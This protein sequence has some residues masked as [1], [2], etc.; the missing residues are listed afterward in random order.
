[1]KII[2]IGAILLLGVN[3][4][5]G[6]TQPPKGPAFDKVVKSFVEGNIEQLAKDLPAMSA[7]YPTHPFT[8]FFK[9]FLAD[10][11]DNN[12]SEALRG[13]SEA[14]KGDP[15]LMEAYMY[16]GIIVNEKGMYE[17]AIEDMANAIKNDDQKLSNLYTLRGEIYGKAEKNEEAFADFK[18]AILLSPS[19]AKNYRGL[20]NTS[21]DIKKNEEAAAITK[22]AIEST[23]SENAGVWA[24]FFLSKN[25]KNPIVLM[26]IMLPCDR[27][28]CI[29]R[30]NYIFS[31]RYFNISPLVYPVLL[32]CWR[33]KFQCLR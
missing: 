10:R 33:R 23:E 26:R 3:I 15:K 20:E 19:I 24:V 5:N 29:L 8:V 18:Q 9:A 4:S 22:K 27:I 6:Q 25:I 30:G 28:L 11:K 21:F 2:F 12:V 1:M 32:A 14:L 31:G 7:I 13:Y 16:R 17:K